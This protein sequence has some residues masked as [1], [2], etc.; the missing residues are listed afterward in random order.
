MAGFIKGFLPVSHL[1]KGLYYR[2]SDEYSYFYLQ[3]IEPEKSN[4]ALEIENNNFWLEIIKTP[5]YQLWRGYAF[6]SLCYKHVANIKKALG[7]K[8]SAKIGSWRYVPKVNDKTQGAQI[9]LLFDRKDDAVTICEIKFSNKPFMITKEYA[10]KLRQKVQTYQRITRT[11][12]Q[13]FIAIISVNGIKKKQI[14]Q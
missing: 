12:K 9:D 11:K 7:I 8:C 13:I 10:N 3:W 2:I 14:R 6:E 1:K 4:L 5:Q